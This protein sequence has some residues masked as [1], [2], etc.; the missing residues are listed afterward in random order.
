MSSLNDDEQQFYRFFA[1]IIFSS[2][3]VQ[4]KINKVN[5]VYTLFHS[6]AVRSI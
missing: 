5:F 1:C 3:Y 4:H 2:S 6:L